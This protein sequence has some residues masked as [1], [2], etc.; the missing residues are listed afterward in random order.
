M[1]PVPPIPIERYLVPATSETPPGL[2][3]VDQPLV[4]GLPATIPLTK[5]LS[6]VLAL[7]TGLAQ[8][9]RELDADVVVTEDTGERRPYQ[10]GGAE[11]GSTERAPARL[12]LLRNGVVTASAPLV[13]GARRRLPEDGDLAQGSV[14]ELVVERWRI[15]A[16]TVLGVGDF[17][18]RITFAWRQIDQGADLFQP[19][20]IDPNVISRL[21]DRRQTQSLLGAGVKRAP[22][23]YETAGTGSSGKPTRHRYHEAKHWKEHRRKELVTDKRVQISEQAFALKEIR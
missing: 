18:S 23:G 1:T 21:R 13:T 17:G 19:P 11:I 14:V 4:A 15:L 5:E 8:S 12:F 20:P 9:L 16:G 6:L 22:S 7:P 10:A 3:E 2:Q